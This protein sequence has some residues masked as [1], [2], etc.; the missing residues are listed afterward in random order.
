MGLWVAPRNMV[1]RWV[2]WLGPELD[3]RASYSMRRLKPNMHR[4]RVFVQLYFVLYP[5]A[6]ECN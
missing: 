4:T 6:V 3:R 5:R 1:W 2:G